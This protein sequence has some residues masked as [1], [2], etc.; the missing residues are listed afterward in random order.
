MI[1][2]PS[3]VKLGVEK[4]FPVSKKPEFNYIEFCLSGFKKTFPILAEADPE[5]V[6]EWL[7]YTARSFNSRAN[8]FGDDKGGAFD[9]L[10]CMIA[11]AADVVLE[12]CAARE[13]KDSLRAKLHK[14]WG[15][16]DHVMIFYKAF[17]FERNA[18]MSVVNHRDVDWAD[19]MRVI[20]E[21]E[22]DNIEISAVVRE[23]AETLCEPAAE[24]TTS[25]NRHRKHNDRR[26]P[27][28]RA[29]QSLFEE[30]S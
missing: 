15:L 10:R 8:D 25:G 11:A 17:Q 27:A 5:A 29:V 30:V 12:V 3:A 4:E 26:K 24:I 28:S 22:Q 16:N 1:H 13:I 9:D 18:S 20:E 21:E 23:W 7:Y 6:S 19:P 14:A 2:P